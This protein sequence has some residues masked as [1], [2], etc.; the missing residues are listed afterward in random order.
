M[1]KNN[2][3]LTA[4]FMLFCMDFSAQCRQTWY[5]KQVVKKWFDPKTF[6]L[7]FVAAMGVDVVTRREL[8]VS[9]SPSVIIGWMYISLACNPN[10]YAEQGTIMSLLQE[11]S[12]MAGGAFT[13]LLVGPYIECIITKALRSS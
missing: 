6:A 1:I 2:A 13:Y 10:T 12:V 3:T 4:I 7:G 5:D 8:K 11:S 9:L